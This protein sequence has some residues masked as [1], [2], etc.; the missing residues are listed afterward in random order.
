MRY[1]QITLSC[2]ISLPAGRRECWISSIWALSGLVIA[3]RVLHAALHAQ[4]CGALGVTSNEM[5]PVQNLVRRSIGA[6]TL[7]ALV[8][9]AAFAASASA[10]KFPPNGLRFFAEAG[11]RPPSRTLITVETNRGSLN[12]L[13][14]RAVRDLTV[15]VTRSMEGHV[16]G[17]L[18]V[19]STKQQLVMPRGAST[20]RGHRRNV[21]LSQ[22]PRVVLHALPIRGL[23][24]G[25]V[26]LSITGLAADTRSVSV[27]LD[28]AGRGLIGVTHGC[29]V[30]PTF[31]LYAQRRGASPVAVNSGVSCD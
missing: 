30:K 18:T 22:T 20:L 26:L 4:L 23:H 19:G 25:P 2:P 29:P 11:V 31:R 3:E 17:Q 24:G 6:I 7:L 12:D 15:K 8:S 1:R 21:V 10:I 14:L 28:G 9:L 13:S 16:V 27:T 5:P